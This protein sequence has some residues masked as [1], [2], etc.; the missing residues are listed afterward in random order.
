MSYPIMP[1]LPM[2]MAKGIHKT[3]K[4]NADTQKTAARRTNAGVS[5]T[6]FPTWAFECDLDRLVGNESNAAAAVMQFLGTFVAC[7][8]VA[9]PFLFTDPQDHAVTYGNS[10]MYNLAP[11]AG[12]TTTGDGSSTQFQL[13]R[14]IGGVGKD[15]VQ[16]LNGSITVKVNGS[17]VASNTYSV[18]STGVVTFNVAPANG[19]TLAWQ[20]SFYFLCRFADNELDAARV[21][22]INDSASDQWNVSSIKFESEFA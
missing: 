5:Y 7:N 9:S 19:A 10:L 6:P 1:A 3:P 22:T 20:G 15:L 12:M 13:G 8:G 14:L 2:S 17:V 18:S 4:V 11:G 16:M 21:F